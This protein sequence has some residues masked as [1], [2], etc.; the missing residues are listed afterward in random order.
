MKKIF[1]VCIMAVVLMMAMPAHAQ[2]IKFGV[3]GGLNM[4]KLDFKNRSLE[5]VK[6]NS[7]GFFIGPMAEVTLPIIGLGVDGAL[8]YL[9]TF[10]MELL[11][12]LRMFWDIPHIY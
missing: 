2:L 5:Q 9:Q 7:T 12:S 11:R 3:K 6:E 4:S 1:S 8:L 10:H